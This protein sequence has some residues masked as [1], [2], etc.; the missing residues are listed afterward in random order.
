MGVVVCWR[1]TNNTS[2]SCI[3]WPER[4]YC[5][6]QPS[7]LCRC[8]SLAGQGQTQEL[9]C[10]VSWKKWRDPST[11]P[12]K[13]SQLAMIMKTSEIQLD[14][15][16]VLIYNSHCTSCWL[17]WLVYLN[18]LWILPLTPQRCCAI[19]RMIMVTSFKG[20]KCITKTCLVISNNINYKY[21]T[22]MENNI[23]IYQI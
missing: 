15:F 4:A 11:K 16:S 13:K 6:G 14:S 23:R 12:S 10:I 2:Q 3:L 8:L 1:H 9:D 17:A 19:A 22:S 18:D 21:F 20:N 5:P 7:L